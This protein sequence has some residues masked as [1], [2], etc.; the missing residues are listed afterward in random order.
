SLG[1]QL[2]WLELGEAEFERQE[3]GREKI[4]GYEK[5][6]EIGNAAWDQM[7]DGCGQGSSRSYRLPPHPG[8]KLILLHPQPVKTNRPLARLQSQKIIR[9]SASNNPDGSSSAPLSI[10]ADSEEARDKNI[11]VSLRTAAR[12]PAQIPEMLLAPSHIHHCT[13]NPTRLNRDFQ[14]T[15]RDAGEAGRLRW[16]I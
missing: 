6:G 10:L 11:S 9:D 1:N 14:M 16:Q 12:G 8:T 7:D 2:E 4:L 15:R 3:E 5:Y 13:P